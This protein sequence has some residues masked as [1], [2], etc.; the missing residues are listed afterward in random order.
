MFWNYSCNSNSFCI[1]VNSKRYNIVIEFSCFT[2][3]TNLHSLWDSY[4]PE[5]AHKWSYTEW[6]NEIDRLSD[7]EIAAIC[8]GTV[9]DWAKET[10]LIT[11]EVY[12]SS[13][14][15]G[16]VSYDYIYKWTPVIEKQLAKG[17]IR[18]AFLL[19][20]IFDPH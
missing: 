8:Q 13:P 15:E 12:N 20:T 19:N 10:F 17:G 2:T 5:S 9:D 7:T 11:R 1:S 3:E 6:R 14:R 4:L 18:L 16:K